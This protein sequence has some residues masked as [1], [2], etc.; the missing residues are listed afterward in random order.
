MKSR[1]QARETA[2]QALYQCDIQKTW[3]P[4]LVDLFFSIY[5]SKDEEDLEVA[6]Q[7]NC[8][9]ARSLIDGVIINME[10]IDRE[11]TANSAHWSMKRMAIVDRNILRLG[12]Y[13]ISFVSDIPANVSINEA[14]E[15][16]KRYG[17]DDSPMFI[18]GI[19][20]TI[21]VAFSKDDSS[22]PEDAG[23]GKRVA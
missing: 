1:R 22:A 7:E 15:I 13:E 8:A 3:S 4:E 2:L 18:N 19:L 23:R 6:S 16:A 11:I 21:A 14:I 12:V 17:V 10:V 5:K 9:F 20:D